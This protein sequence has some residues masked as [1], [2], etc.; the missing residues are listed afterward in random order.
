MRRVHGG[1]ARIENDPNNEPGY[2]S[3]RILN[4]EKKTLIA[5]YAAQNFIEDKD[6]IILEAGTTV[7]MMLKFMTCSNL[8]VITNGL[9]N[10]ENLSMCLPH[11]TVLSCGGMMRSVANTFV[12]PQAIDFFQNVR[13]RTLFLSATGLAIPGGITDPNL[14]EIQIKQAMAGSAARVILLIDS[15]KFGIRSLSSIL[16]MERI[17]IL[18]TDAGASENDMSQLREMGIDV[19]VAV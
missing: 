15:T 12:G 19:H 10:L 14:F 5:R 18:V 3:K 13:A 7:G 6:I 9:A 16:P 11:M 2:K 8:T 1:V 4:I 17:N